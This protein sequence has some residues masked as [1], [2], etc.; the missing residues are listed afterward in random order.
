ME[1]GAVSPNDSARSLQRATCD[2]LRDKIVSSRSR[3]AKLVGVYKV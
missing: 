1:R 3:S 2:E